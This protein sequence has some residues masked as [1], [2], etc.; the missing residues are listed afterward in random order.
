MG[1]RVRNTSGETANRSGREAV[2]HGHRPRGCRRAASGV[3]QRRSAL[4]V[5]PRLGGGGVGRRTRPVSAR[6]VRFPHPQRARPALWRLAVRVRFD[7][8]TRSQR[9]QTMAGRPH[10]KGRGRGRRGVGARWGHGGARCGRRRRQQSGHPG[11][12]P[13]PARRD[14]RLSHQRP[15]PPRRRRAAQRSPLPRPTHHRSGGPERR[16]GPPR[17][18]GL[19]RG[20]PELGGTE[21]SDLQCR[22]L[23]LGPPPRRR[24]H[25]HTDRVR[26]WT[27]GRR[28][29]SDAGR[30]W[31]HAAA[32]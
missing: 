29:A 15:R 6:A 1:Y 21:A 20:P 22:S 31:T 17:C 30:R 4:C 8:A 16:R 13:V 2:R 7:P 3:R 5:P 28:V 32:A 23:R 25:R 9:P 12:E 18:A 10:R 14:R 24:R 11:L 19:V 27:G 26:R